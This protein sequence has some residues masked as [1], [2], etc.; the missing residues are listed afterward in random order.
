ML[1]H[2]HR[3]KK[4]KCESKRI[5]HSELLQG[6]DSGRREIGEQIVEQRQGAERVCNSSECVGRNVLNKVALQIDGRQ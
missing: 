4:Q 1:S 3:R 2:L 5:T 6:R